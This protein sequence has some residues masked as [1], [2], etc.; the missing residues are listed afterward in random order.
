MPNEETYIEENILTSVRTMSLWYMNPEPPPSSPGWW[1]LHSTWVQPGTQGSLPLPPAR[2]GS[3]IFLGGASCQH[4]SPPERPEVP[5]SP[6]CN[7]ESY[8]M[9]VI[10]REPATVPHPCSKDL[11]LPKYLEKKK[12]KMKNSNC[13]TSKPTRKLQSSTEG[14]SGV[15]IGI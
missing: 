2:K 3:S 9:A 11:E 8:S 4:F 13:L 1:K 15:R 12:T 7:A 5:C 14:G 6:A 10:Q